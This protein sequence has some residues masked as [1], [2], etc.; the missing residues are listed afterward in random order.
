MDFAHV[1][2]QLPLQRLL[3]HLDLLTALRGRGPQRKGPCPL[4]A[5]QAKGR[6][7]SVQLDKNVFHCF[8]PKCAKKGDV[9]DLWAAL[10]GLSLR[11]AAWE[12][13]TI[14]N[15][16]PAPRTEKRHG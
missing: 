5:D 7:F 3:E 16:E 9:I 12:L 13:V 6:T 2:S 14:F 8:D 15:L 11:D 1:K 4:H 10:K